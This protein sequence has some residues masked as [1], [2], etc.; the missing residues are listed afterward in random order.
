M[1]KRRNIAPDRGTRTE[2]DYAA[3]AE[4]AETNIPNL[5]GQTINSGDTSREAARAMLARAL[6]AD[7]DNDSPV[8]AYARALIH[9]GRPSLSAAFIPKPGRSAYRTPWTPASSST[10]PS[11]TP[12][13]R[14]LCGSLSNNT[15]SAKPRPRPLQ[16]QGWPAT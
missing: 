7:S 3:A 13:A 10:W 9:R 12:P 16:R 2:A 8:E 11:R 14:R 5:T 4:W 6:V 1:T 15:S